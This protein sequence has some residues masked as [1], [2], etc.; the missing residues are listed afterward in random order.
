M[1]EPLQ[2]LSFGAR[3]EAALS[4]AGELE[5]LLSV[6]LKQQE[7]A[8]LIVSGGSS[9]IGLFHALRERNL[10]WDRIWIVPSDERVVPANHPDRNETMIRQSLMRS[11]AAAAGLVSLISSGP[12]SPPLFGPFEA[13]VLG[14]G[15]DGHTA[16][17]FPGSP[18][19][20]AALASEHMTYRLQVPQLDARRVSLTPAAI[21]KSKQLFLLFFGDGKRQV[22]ERALAGGD[23]AEY[24]VR[25]VLQQDRVPVRVYWAP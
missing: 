16:S 23:V 9:P 15:E 8:A 18:D 22:F 12:L 11:R 3:D 4:L 19:L 25:F 21:L 17:L 5:R 13:A 7:E 14:M 24:P 6:A 1:A 20:E 10:P 2:F